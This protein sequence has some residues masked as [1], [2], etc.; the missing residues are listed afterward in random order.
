M[1]ERLHD[2]MLFDRTK[3][4]VADMTGLGLVEVTRKKTGREL[5]TVLLDKCPHCEGNALTYSYDYLCRKIKSE[6]SRAFADPSVT[7]VSVRVHQGLADH[8]I[9]SRYFDS[10]CTNEWATKRIYVIP[11]AVLTKTDYELETF[12]ESTFSVPVG[13]FL[14]Y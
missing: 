8:M 7:G 12:R 5:S 13:A 9:R 4:R 14:L 1:M 2:E 3:T 10:V 11:N 6:L